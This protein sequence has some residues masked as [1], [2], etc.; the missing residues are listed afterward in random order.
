MIPTDTNVLVTHGPPLGILDKTDGRYHAPENVGCWDLA[1]RIR[2][3]PELKLHVFGHI[4]CAYGWEKLA[5]VTYVNASI[6]N[7]RYEH[8]N[9][10][11]VFD[12]ETGEVTT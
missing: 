7:E 4:H 2:E 11:I 6:C 5:G 12:T 3:L 8:S 1:K 10:P 9:R